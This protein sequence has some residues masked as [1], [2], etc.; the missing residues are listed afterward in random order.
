M[1]NLEEKDRH[2]KEKNNSKSKITKIK[3]LKKSSKGITFSI[4]FIAIV[5][6]FIISPFGF[7]VHNL[8]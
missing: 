4:L 7:S 6:F 3:E 2:M 1:S 8:L 5:D